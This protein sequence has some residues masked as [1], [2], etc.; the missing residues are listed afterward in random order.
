MSRLPAL[1]PLN[2]L[3]CLIDR[4]ESRAAGAG[5]RREDVKASRENRE[6]AIAVRNFLVERGN[7][8]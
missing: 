2:N 1:S 7:R 3:V 8:Q 5:Q 6:V 4:W